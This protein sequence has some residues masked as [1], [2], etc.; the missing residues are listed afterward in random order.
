MSTEPGTYRVSAEKSSPFKGRFADRIRGESGV[1]AEAFSLK[2]GS[3]GRDV[4]RSVRASHLQLDVEICRLPYL[5]RELRNG[6]R[7]ESTGLHASR[8][9]G[10]W[11]ETRY[12]TALPHS[13]WWS[14]QS[15]LQRMSGYMRSRNYGSAGV[16][17]LACNGAGY[18]LGDGRRQKR[19][20]RER[21]SENDPK[22]T[23]SH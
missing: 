6:G 18:L 9:S 16:G 17:D 15:R 3:G 10:R 7:R 12:G 5:E 22:Q 4:D 20:Q 19:E 11:A 1:D 13:L 14:C 21:R 8:Y 23:F 2:D